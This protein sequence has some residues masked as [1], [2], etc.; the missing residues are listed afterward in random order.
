MKIKKC[1][2]LLLAVIPLA[3]YSA[4]ALVMRESG[5]EPIFVQIKE[6]LRQS[7]DL[8]AELAKLAALQRE[9]SLRVDKRWAGPKF[10]EQISFPKNFTEEEALAVI[11]KLQQLPAVE[12]VVALSAYNLE[13]RSG[14]FSREFAGNQAIPDVARRGFDNDRNS[15]G[16]H[17]PPDIATALTAKHAPN[18]IIVRW[19]D[20]Y[21]WKDDRT[22]FSQRTANLH[23]QAG[24]RVL[25]EHRF[26]KNQLIQ[27]LEF[28][29]AIGSVAS[30]LGRYRALA[31]VDY[32]Q[33]DYVYTANDVTPNDTYYSYQWSLPKIRAPRAWDPNLGGTQGTQSVRVAIGDT[34]VNPNITD[35]AQNLWGGYNFVAN[36]GNYFDDHGHGTNVASIIGAKG[37]NGQGLT[38]VAWNTSLMH[39]KVCDAG[40]DCYSSAIAPAINYAWQNFA[41]AINLSLGNAP[42]TSYD[43]LQFEAIK[44]ARDNNM[45]VVA[46]AGNLGVNLENPGQLVSPAC[47]PFA[48]VIA[49]G[50]T[51]SADSRSGFSNYGQYRVELGAPGESILG[52][53]PS[54]SF[55]YYT[56]TS[57]AAPH[58]A[59]ALELVKSKYPWESYAGIKDRVLMGVDS[60]ASLNAV[61]RTGGRLNLATSLMKRNMMR[62]LSTRARVEG[63]DRRMIGGFYIAGPGTLKVAIRGLGP[64]M[65][66]QQLG[67]PLLNNPQIRLYNSAGQQI[68][69]NDDWNNLPQDQKN[70]LAG[71]TP[72][73]SREAAMFQELSTGAYTVF[74]ES[75]DGQYGVGLFE[76][77]E[78]EGNSD[79]QTRLVNVSTRCIV[80]TGNEVAIAGTILGDPA[81]ANSVVP[82]RR[83]L[84]F[85]K[86]PSLPLAGTLPNPYIELKN[87]AGATI[88]A[89]NQWQDIDGSSTGLQ[90]KL[91]HSN[92]A[93]SNGNESAVWPTVPP[94]FY[95][96]ILRDAGGASGLGLVEFYEY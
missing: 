34:G 32:A 30:M 73:D 8:D 15:R 4:S 65:A 72:P 48:N 3:P 67:V 94:G 74:V 78:M 82:K 17:G 83:I 79:E 92:F 45:V 70:A 56:G 12:K 54:G 1:F 27:V 20:E 42:T 60:I 64:S 9:S 36:N 38:G 10:L 61:F 88:A 90:E 55:Q 84:A 75:Q 22:G 49:V 58:V 81:Q 24:C 37:N 29:A 43:T 16:S 66:N 31:E 2:L 7:D 33:P 95:T 23:A 91:V 11:A 6:S 39:F 87:G 59:G 50:S 93:P 89:N 96:A 85:G 80:G 19:K 68:F 46:S 57:Q 63:G 13:F 26:T 14:D 47:I 86:G 41:I 76:I 28:D 40:G 53:T 5:P 21:V 77:Y 18:R 44:N 69:F 25:N 52:F 51:N 71:I 62:N 35:F